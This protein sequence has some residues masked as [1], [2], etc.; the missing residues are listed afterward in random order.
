M[1]NLKKVI[2]D[3]MKNAENRSVDWERE[4][5]EVDP[6]SLPHWGKYRYESGRMVAFEQVLSVIER[7]EEKK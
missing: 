4:A 1:E 5:Y 6:M 3:L 7:M 2:L